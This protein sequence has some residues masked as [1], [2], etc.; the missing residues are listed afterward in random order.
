MHLEWE[1]VKESH[2]KSRLFVCGLL[3]NRS[4]SPSLDLGTESVVISCPQFWGNFAGACLDATRRQRCLLRNRR[5]RKRSPHEPRYR[6][7]QIHSMFADLF[8]FVARKTDRFAR[9]SISS[10]F[11]RLLT[12]HKNPHSRNGINSFAHTHSLTTHF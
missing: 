12:R 7:C 4:K 9:V 2:E 11:V 8:A 10:H 1:F 5:T 3:Q 6:Q